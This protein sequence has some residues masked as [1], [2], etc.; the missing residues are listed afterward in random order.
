MHL[1]FYI[2]INKD[3]G[4]VRVRDR[5]ES[6]WKFVGIKSYSFRKYIPTN[7]LLP[8]PCLVSTSLFGVELRN[9][10]VSIKGSIKVNC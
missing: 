3:L 9:I 4:P 7:Q 2:Y 1:F 10:A 5:V 6:K 8:I